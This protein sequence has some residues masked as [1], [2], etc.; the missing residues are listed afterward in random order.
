MNPRLIAERFGPVPTDVEAPV[1]KNVLPFGRRATQLATTMYA[2]DG[3]S[4]R[5]LLAGRQAGPKMELVKAFGGNEETLEAI[6]R[7]LAW[8][9]SHQF[10]DG[11]WSL[12]DFN[13]CCKGHK[14]C[15]GHG[16]EKADAAATGFALL[17][18]LG[19]GQTHVSG[20]HRAA[21]RRGIDW[22]VAGQKESGELNPTNVGNARMYSHAIATI[23]MCEAFSMTQDK[24]LR[25]P[26]QR[27]IDFIVKAQHKASGGWRYQPNQ[28]AD[29]SVVG[30]QVMA[31]KSGEIAGLDVPP[32]TFS[33]VT[34]WLNQVEAQGKNRGQFG[35]T[36]RGPNLAMTAEG[37]LCRRYLGTQI[38]DP[39]L[40]AG[41]DHLLKNL[42]QKGRET[43]YYWYYAT[44]LMFHLSPDYWEV[45]NNAQRD[46]LTQSQHKDGP[47]AGTWD[48]KDQWE[49][50]GGRIYT[51]SLRVM[52][53]EVYFRHQPL[54]KLFEE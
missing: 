15:T 32:E 52:M 9:A 51:T 46:M 25:E 44:Q 30:W 13:K 12:H 2:G 41:A 42:P 27:A 4:I 23:A 21:V 48:P 19:D 53:L 8:F 54:Y 33:L 47:L 29:T 17:G 31:L 10:P 43:S 40:R 22:L 6:R 38:T 1:T 26:T 7:S 36:G 18:F 49:N 3:K 28:S 39:S 24:K 5:R 35:Y 20:Q 50:R 37:L 11:H 34:K 16:G 45:W 14:K